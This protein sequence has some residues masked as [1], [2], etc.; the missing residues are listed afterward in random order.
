MITSQNIAIII[1]LI[2]LGIFGGFTHC[3]G[4]CGPFVLTQVS[5]RLNDIKINDI[6]H[7]KRIS[8]IALLPYHLGRITTYSFIGAISSLFSTSLKNILGF[9]F[10]SAAMLI[11]AALIFIKITL[12]NLKIELPIKINLVKK[13]DLIVF[14][15]KF[16]GE[17][18]K[19]LFLKPYNFRG[20][21]LGIL[22]GFI[23]CG[24][25]YA[26]VIAAST[27]DNFLIAAFAMFCFGVATIPGLF[28]TAAGGY[29]F[30]QKYRSNLNILTKVILLINSATLFIIA[31]G[32]IFNKI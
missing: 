3:I 26:A 25:L 20:Y 32:L 29:L 9:K 27:I 12:P 23:P 2:S 5:N 1:S 8:G 16:F 24:L 31:L 14:F 15:K 28:I 18:I 13:L 10:L 22:L 4:M 19:S 6:S 17:T 11:I 7:F 30:F 21:L